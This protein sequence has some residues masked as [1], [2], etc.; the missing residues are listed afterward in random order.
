MVDARPP[1]V[2]LPGDV[3]P[4][5]YALDLTIVPA[6]PRATGIV[7]IAS[8]VV[9]PT[10]IV[11]LNATD[12]EISRA[13]LAGAPARVIKGGEDFVGLAADRELPVGP[14]AIEVAFSA[15]IDRQKSRGLYAETENGEAYAYTFFEPVD[16]RRAF[17]CFDEPAYKVPWQLTF[18]VDK[19]HVAL[20][21]TP[22][23]SETPEQNGMKR[24]ELAESK[25]LP[26]YLVAFVVGPFEVVDGGT[27]GRVKTPIRFI[28][29]KGRAAELRYAKEVTP[30]AVAALETYFDMDYPF[31]KLDVAVVPRYWGTMEHPGIVAMGQPLTLIRPTEETRSRKQFYTNILVHELAHYWFGDLVT[32]RWWDDTWLNEALAQWNDAIVTNAVEP[33]WRLQDTRIGQATGAMESD[34]TLAVHPI[35][36]PVLT[37]EAIEASFDNDITYAKGAAVLR[38][39]EA[40]DATKFRAF[41]RA[42]LAKHAWG[43]ASAD[44]MFAVMRDQLGAPVEEA[45]R[46][47]IEQPGVPRIGSKLTCEPGKPASL[48]LDQRRALPK[49]TVDPTPRLW[50][51]PVC[52]RYGNATESH[53][54]C[55]QLDTASATLELPMTGCPTWVLPNAGGNGYYRSTLDPE[56]AKQLLGR[57]RL[58]A[59]AKPTAAEKMMMVADLRAAVER[60]E[61]AFDKLLALVPLIAADPDEKFAVWAFAA[62]SFNVSALDDAMYAKAVKYYLATFGPPARKLGWTRAKT[63]SDER[64]DLRRAFVPAVGSDDPTLRKQATPLVIRWLTDRSGLE[65]DMVGG[66]MRAATERG[67]AALFDRVLA[68]AGKARDRRDQARILGALSGFHD[69]ALAKRALDLVLT[70]ERD[71]RET[72]VIVYGL[73]FQRETRAIADAFVEANLDTMLSRMRDD[74]AAGFLAALAGSSC[75][76]ERA[77]RMRALVEPRAKKIGGA[78]VAVTRGLEQTQQCITSFQR[79]LPALQR[80][81]AKFASEP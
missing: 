16:A 71:L 45:M 57:T 41:I 39:F 11:W 21:N 38:M 27:G 79:Q 42:Y 10:R 15:G 44:D 20:G 77:N 25:P 64:H 29:P 37:R 70:K 55:K 14:L 61:L 49:G 8:E 68:A 80:L 58:A 30:R 28:I 65:D 78:E 81:L 54:A 9:K 1:D 19:A 12:L 35:R 34:E 18:H 76:A 32:M 46:T 26:S 74:T 60:D 62:S 17:P 22:V 3:R 47:F 50:K 33:A 6:K 66:A 59:I 67:D 69:P 5:R 36:Q 53:A 40:Q 72:I 23:V 4:T 75:T 31:G 24:V 73:M 48:A 52:V 56:V 7:K 63:D 2:R 51:L 43:T 13:T